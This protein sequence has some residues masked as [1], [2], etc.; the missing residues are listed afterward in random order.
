MQDFN[1]RGKLGSFLIEF[2]EA[3]DLPSQ[4]PVI[5]VA[6][7]PLQVHE[8][9]AGPNEEGA[10]PGGERFDGVFLAMPNRVSLHIQ[11]NNVR[12]LIRALLLVESGDPSIFQLLDPLGWFEDSI[13][14]GDVKV[15]H[16]PVILDVPV[17]GSLKY[18]FVVFNVVMESA[19]LFSKAANFA[20]LLGIA[21]GDGCEEPFSNG[22][23]NVG[24][25]VRWAAKVVATVPGNIGGSRLSTGRTGRG[26]QFLAGEAL[27][28]L[29][30]PFEDIWAGW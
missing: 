14:K 8:V 6:D 3:G 30:E 23:E 27:E 9:T 19:D 17:G 12:G 28:R 24:I 25:E 21:L 10:E 1:L 5:K 16:P 15:G 22:S 2:A 13:A 29:I 11:V 7:V 4:P 18:V 20:G 26:M